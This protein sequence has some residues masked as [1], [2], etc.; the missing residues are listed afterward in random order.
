MQAVA[1]LAEHRCISCA[2]AHC[3]VI[4]LGLP[5][6]ATYTEAMIRAN[7]KEL[8]CAT[9]AEVLGLQASNVSA[10]SAYEVY[11]AMPKH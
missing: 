6:A 8:F 1:C 9:N 11:K 3:I 10:T 5:A 7:F 2:L 4:P